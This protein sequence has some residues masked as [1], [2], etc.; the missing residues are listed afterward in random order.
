LAREVERRNKLATT[1]WWKEERDGVFLDYN[2]NAWD[3][4]IASAYSIRH[5]GLVSTPF[6]WAELADIDHRAMDLMSFK[7]RWTEVG[8][9]TDG[10]DEAAGRLEGLLEMV[11]TD[12]ENGLGD[13][14]WPPHY[15]KMPGEPPRVQPSKMRK[16]NWE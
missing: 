3:K 8:D 4:T 5:T 13:A 15:P 9:L 10:I 6:E 16:E 1:A 11:A 2:Q 7:D 14:P 12:E